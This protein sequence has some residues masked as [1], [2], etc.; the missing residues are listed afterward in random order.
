MDAEGHSGRESW[1]RKNETAFPAKHR[2]I[3]RTL[4]FSIGIILG[5]A[6]C[7][8]YQFGNNSLHRRDLQ[9]IHVPIVRNDS[10]RP[11]LGVQVTEALQKAIQLKTPYRVVSD[12]SADSTLTCRVVN[13][14]K[15]VLTETL[16]DEPRALEATETIEVTWVDRQGNVLFENRFLPP[17]ELAFL[18]N[19]A[20]DFVPE[21]GQSMASTQQRAA[22]RLADEIVNQ[23]EFR[24]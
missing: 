3:A 11:L 17:G 21:A 13:D 9:T 5:V 20:V 23:M 12:P 4:L 8:G 18:F 16:T 10:W 6:G 14:T 2:Q 15:R 22:E 19:Q 1:R 7:A 24:W